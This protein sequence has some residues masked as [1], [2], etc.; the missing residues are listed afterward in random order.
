MNLQPIID[1]LDADKGGFR[2]IGNVV[3]FSE[4]VAALKSSPSAFVVA[5][6]EDWGQPQYQPGFFQQNQVNTFAVMIGIS[7]AG[8]TG[9]HGF[10]MLTDLISHL[11]AV[12]INWVHPDAAGPNHPTI[13]LR[14]RAMGLTPNQSLWW[15]QSYAYTIPY[16]KAG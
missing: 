11:N 14:G 6:A 16:R 4:A 15:Q 3:G 7:A 8:P 10:E 1:R 13:A 12:L 5:E 9:A 2:H